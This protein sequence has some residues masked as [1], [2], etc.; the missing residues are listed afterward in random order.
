MNLVVRP[1]AALEIEEAFHWYEVRDTGLGEMFLVDLR[2]T[3]GAI[4]KSPNRYRVIHRNTR[5]VLL[6]RFP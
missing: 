6:R 1:A 3:L 4:V 5:R 2:S